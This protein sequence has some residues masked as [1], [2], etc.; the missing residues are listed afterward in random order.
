MPTYVHEPLA[1]DAVAQVGGSFPLRHV[2]L[3]QGGSSPSSAGV[4]CFSSVH[5]PISFFFLARSSSSSTSSYL[6]YPYVEAKTAPFC[7]RCPGSS[8][9]SGKPSSLKRPAEE[10][11]L[12]LFYCLFSFRR[13]SENSASDSASG[14]ATQGPNVIITSYFLVY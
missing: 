1:A 13:Q 11:P 5:P 2:T 6:S 9:M 12:L 10:L 4:P 14:P 3:F 8:R 7:F